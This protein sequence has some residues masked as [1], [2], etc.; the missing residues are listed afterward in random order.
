MIQSE[1]MASLG[2]MVAGIAHEIN[3]P[4]GYVNNNV[5]IVNDFF[6]D[7]ER[8]MLK[9]GDLYDEAIKKPYDKVIFKNLIV[10]VLKHYHH[11]NKD[12]AV[13]EAKELLDDSSHGLK[14]IAE[15]VTNL[16]SF[17][18]LDRQAIDQFDVCD[19]LDSA[20]K[21]ANSILKESNVD[22]VKSYGENAVIEC[23]PSKINQV[24]LNVITNA[25]QAIPKVG[26][27]ITINVEKISDTVSITFTDTG[28]GMS[29]ET[30]AKIFDPFFT[31]KPVG[32]GTGLGMSII[33]KI[34]Q[35]HK[36]QIE[37][38]SDQGQGTTVKL[39][40]PCTANDIT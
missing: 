26:G 38:E 23:N 17:S 40:F 6:S 25:A 12:G 34:V 8:L 36:G 1:K 2:Q 24:F 3:T 33:Y 29:A 39:L 11:L 30:R 13:D 18:R 27:Q 21:I 32:E 4:L 9:L 35:E 7:I 22:V 20:L 14:D 5:S 16:R 37:I 15:L 28:E 31:T 10:K 19:G